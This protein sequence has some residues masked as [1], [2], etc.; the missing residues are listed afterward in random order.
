MDVA[1]DDVALAGVRLE[2]ASQAATLRAARA[3][4]SS[5]ALASTQSSV[6]IFT[7]K[8]QRKYILVCIIHTR[9]HGASA[10]IVV[11]LKFEI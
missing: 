4:D 1:P 3:H 10:V 2:G 8:A 6:P 11:R 5:S 7:F 9:I